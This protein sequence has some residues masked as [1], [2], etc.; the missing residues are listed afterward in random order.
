MMDL[1]LLPRLQHGYSV[2]VEGWSGADPLPSGSYLLRILSS[3]PNLPLRSHQGKTSQTGN[4]R[5]KLG[6]SFTTN[7]VK[8][9]YLPDRDLTVFRCVCP[10]A[11][12]IPSCQHEYTDGSVHTYLCIIATDVHSL[13]TVSTYVGTYVQYVLYAQC[14]HTHTLPLLQGIL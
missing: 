2:V 10:S 13:C 5:E 1:F 4:G 6:A 12:S 7:V 3:S 14:M 11:S 9:Y 8:Q